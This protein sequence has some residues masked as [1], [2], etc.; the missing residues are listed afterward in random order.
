VR[1]EGGKE[2]T[3][4]FE[5]ALEAL[6]IKSLDADRVTA[7]HELYQRFDTSHKSTPR[8]HAYLSLLAT[9]PD[10]RGRGVGQ[11]LLAADLSEWDALGIPTYLEST[12]PTNDHRYARAGYAPIGGFDVVLDGARVTSMWR[13]VAGATDLS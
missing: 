3:P 2:L 12:N 11:A 8:Q 4:E 6:I 10:H 1:P 5:A 7:L 13:N 9:H